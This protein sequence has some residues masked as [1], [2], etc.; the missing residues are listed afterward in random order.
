MTALF[1]MWTPGPF[2]LMVIMFVFFFV[3]ISLTFTTVLTRWIFRINERIELLNQIRDE[4]K[5][6][7]ERTEP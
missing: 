1:A 4:L 5:K 3:A 6:I 2:E 7:N